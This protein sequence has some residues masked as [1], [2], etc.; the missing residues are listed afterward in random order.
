[1]NNQENIKVKELDNWGHFTFVTGKNSEEI[2]SIIDQ[3]IWDVN[4]F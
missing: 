3:V 2:T 4:N 1:V